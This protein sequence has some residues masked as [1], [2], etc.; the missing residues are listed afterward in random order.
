M[1]HCSALHRANQL[2]SWPILHSE[3]GHLD[4]TTPQKHV[5]FAPLD[6]PPPCS[7]IDVGLGLRKDTLIICHVEQVRGEAKAS[8]GRVETSRR[9][10]HNDAASGS[11]LGN[12]DLDD[13]AVEKVKI[14]RF[15]PATRDGQKVAVEMPIEVSLNLY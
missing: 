2:R 10:L 7:T 9:R 6:R 11:S 12:M 3:F 14:W 15:E 1:P 5:T 4:K 13:R 8:R